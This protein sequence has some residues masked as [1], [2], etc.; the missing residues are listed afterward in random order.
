M[1]IWSPFL[2]T[3]KKNR[4][5]QLY[6]SPMYVYNA[7]CSVVHP[8]SINSKTRP[9][10][11]H[12]WIDGFGKNAALWK[13]KSEKFD[14]E[15]CRINKVVVSLYIT[16]LKRTIFLYSLTT[17]NNWRNG[18]EWKWRMDYINLWYCQEGVHRRARSG[19]WNHVTSCAPCDNFG[20]MVGKR[21]H[22]MRGGWGIMHHGLS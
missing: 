21:V 22:G 20:R 19:P 12:L 3:V 18:S 7:W 16:H 6:V 17:I 5:Y 11:V 9:F 13:K 14:V 1:P 10:T 8:A 2:L 15:T 4:C